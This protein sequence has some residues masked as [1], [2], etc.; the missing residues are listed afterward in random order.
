MNFSAAITL[1]ITPQ[2]HMSPAMTFV[3]EVVALITAS[4]TLGSAKPT[5]PPTTTPT[6]LPQPNSAPTATPPTTTTITTVV[7][8]LFGSGARSV[9]SV[10]L[11]SSQL[12]FAAS[13]AL[14]VAV[15]KRSCL[16]PCTQTLS[17]HTPKLLPWSTNNSPWLR[18]NTSKCPSSSGNSP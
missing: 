7:M 2:L 10:S 17:I 11:A 12:S 4:V 1:T 3:M 6:T 13:A 18:R 15:S 16:K 8:I 5:L 14:S 9:P